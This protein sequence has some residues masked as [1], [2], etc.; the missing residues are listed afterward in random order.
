MSAEFRSSGLIVGAGKDFA[1][2][3]RSLNSCCG[4]VSAVAEAGLSW[5]LTPA[6]ANSP[7]RDPK[8]HKERVIGRHDIRVGTCGSRQSSP[9]GPGEAD[10][11]VSKINSNDAR[12]A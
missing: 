2:S 3:A 8:S 7:A 11:E 12:S 9:F 6:T 4:R 1:R 5:A 10:P